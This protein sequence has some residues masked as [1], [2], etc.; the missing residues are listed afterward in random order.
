MENE[1]ASLLSAWDIPVTD[2]QQEQFALYR[3]LLLDWNAKINL[4]RI[5]EPDAVTRLHF[6]D[7]LALMRSELPLD[8][9]SLIDVG[10]GAGFPGIPLK[11]MNPSLHLTLLDALDKRCR[12]LQE[13]AD[14]LGLRDTGSV[15]VLHGRAE[16]IG[17]AGRAG[18]L[19]E[20]FDFV[21][22]RA[23]A[24][25]NILCEYA[26]PLLKIGGIFASYK[27][28]D[29]TELKDAEKAM[30]VLSASSDKKIVYELPETEPARAVY[31][32]RKNGPTP[33]KYPRRAGVP[34]KKP[35]Q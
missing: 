19:R 25:L 8:N 13:V 27:L 34:E 26:L 14:R 1:L 9:A 15:T 23:V 10:T 32:I 35:L 17:A 29:D 3:E 31:L 24:K 12:F 20:Q 6:L 22:S 7:S 2:R 11:I 16:D 5:T 33:E 4:T 21:T 30:Q 28:D 18:H